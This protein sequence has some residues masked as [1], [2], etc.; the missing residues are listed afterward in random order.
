MDLDTK[1]EFKRSGR[2]LYCSNM[3]KILE[4]VNSKGLCDQDIAKIAGIALTTLTKWR[5]DNASDRKY[6]I[7]FIE[8]LKTIETVETIDKSTQIDDPVTEIVHW[9]EDGVR[10]GIIGNSLKQILKEFLLS[11]KI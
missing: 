5:R 3:S 4:E 2:G 9:L 1:L 7:R 10:L 11:K 8:R 6:A